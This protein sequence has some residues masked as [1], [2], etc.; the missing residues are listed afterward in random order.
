MITFQTLC[1]VVTNNFSLFSFLSDLEYNPTSAEKNTKRF[2]KQSYQKI[3]M[4]AF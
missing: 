4:I 1:R 3:K 2:S